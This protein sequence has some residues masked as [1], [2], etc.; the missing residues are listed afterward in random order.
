[1]LVFVLKIFG[2]SS[3]VLFEWP[4]NQM[5]ARSPA[6]ELA[7]P[8]PSQTTLPG[9]L[10]AK[11]INWASERAVK[12]LHLTLDVCRFLGISPQMEIP[13]P[14]RRRGFLKR[15]VLFEQLPPSSRI[16]MAVDLILLRPSYEKRLFFIYGTGSYQSLKPRLHSNSVGKC[17]GGDHGLTKV[18][19][20]EQP[21]TGECGVVVSR[22]NS[23]RLAESNPEY[24]FLRVLCL[25][26]PIRRCAL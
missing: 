20:L 9:D 17:Y 2:V 15:H 26:D 8:P 16:L 18:S 12:L 4:L 11:S 25:S 3:H 14:A 10:G 23:S 7:F 6:G 24:K 5:C 21:H 22:I 13:A 19:P 1:M